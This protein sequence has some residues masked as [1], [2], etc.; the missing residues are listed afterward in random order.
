MKHYRNPYRT[1][2]QREEDDIMSE[3]WHAVVLAAGVLGTKPDAREIH[4]VMDAR[5]DFATDIRLA[6][7][8]EYDYADLLDTQRTA[9][10]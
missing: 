6:I 5:L 9:T 1:P 10:F 3:Q 4:A 8:D 2:A 7:E